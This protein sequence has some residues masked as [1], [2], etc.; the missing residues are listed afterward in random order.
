MSV[1]VDRHQRNDLPAWVAL[2]RLTATLVFG[3][4]PLDPLIIIIIIIHGVQVAAIN[5]NMVQTSIINSIMLRRLSSL[6]IL[7]RRQRPVISV[8]ASTAA[9]TITTTTTTTTTPLLRTGVACFSTTV[10]DETRATNGMNQPEKEEN[11]NNSFSSTDTGT[12][13]NHNNT[14]NNHPHS[15]SLSRTALLQAALGHVPEHGWT[16]RAIVAAVQQQNPPVSLSYATTLTAHDLVQYF[17]DQANE[18]LRIE[19]Q[20]QNATSSATLTTLGDNR[21]DG[22]ATTSSSTTT[23]SNNNNNDKYHRGSRTERIHHAMQFRLQQVAPYIRMG[24]WHEGMALGVSQPEAALVTSEQIK[25]IVTTIVQHAADPSEPRPSEFAQWAL[26]AVYV[27]TECHMLSDTSEDYIDTWAFLTRQL[28]QW[29]STAVRG[30][31]VPTDDTAFLVSTLATAVG[32]GLMSVSQF[33]PPSS[34]S[35][36]QAF[37]QV[38]DTASQALNHLASS[39]TRSTNNN[40]ASK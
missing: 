7:V 14:N 22:N 21:N 31:F 23:D 28:Q 1:D 10:S 3:F 6:A 32:H 37:H 18:N 17:M 4:Y 8:V 9:T 15:S 12:D 39:F 35:S 40:N 16:T 27:A 26:G 24:R 13:S 2:R 33:P 25:E 20:Q 11:Q 34:T 29:E 36:L 38:R 30:N 19:L 5:G